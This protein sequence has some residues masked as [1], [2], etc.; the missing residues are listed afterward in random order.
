MTKL[1]DHL[2][3]PIGTNE[4]TESNRQLLFPFDFERFAVELRI[5][6][7]RADTVQFQVRLKDIAT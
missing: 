4:S 6:P 2:R 3:I 7:Q 1:R 5:E